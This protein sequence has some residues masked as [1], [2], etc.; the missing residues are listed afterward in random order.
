MLK[1]DLNKAKK[2]LTDQDLNDRVRGP[3]DIGNTT[4]ATMAVLR[5][6]TIASEPLR[7]RL[8]TFRL[9]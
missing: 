8:N 2:I 6:Q 9:M 7:E 3:C 4:R 5:G 1:A